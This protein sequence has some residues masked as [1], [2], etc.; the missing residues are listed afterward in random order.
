MQIRILRDSDGSMIAAVEV[1]ESAY[2]GVEPIA[3]DGQS[4]ETIEVAEED[5]RDL[6]RLFKR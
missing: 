2:D 3:G 5:F 4:L 6:A 1:N